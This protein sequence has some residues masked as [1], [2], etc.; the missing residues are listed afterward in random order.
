[1][2]TS[3]LG[4]LFFVLLL[5]PGF[6]YRLGTERR[7]QP[8][9]KH[10]GVSTFRETVELVTAS[11]LAVLAA[12]LVFAVYRTFVP[13]HSPD[14]G[15]LIDKQDAYLRQ[16]YAYLAWWALSLILLA[17]GLGYLGARLRLGRLF[18]FVPSLDDPVEQSAWWTAFE[19]SEAENLNKRIICHLTSGAI[20]EGTLWSY[21]PSPDDDDDREIALTA[22]IFMWSQRGS[23]VHHEAGTLIVSAKRIEFLY[24]KYVSDDEYDEATRAPTFTYAELPAS[25]AGY[26]QRMIRAVRKKPGRGRAGRP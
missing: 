23:L 20:V 21:N 2:P 3:A 26:A 10:G 25:P 18:R 19:W 4:A 7:Y 24:V 1:M 13:E 6:C 22:P 15:R 9:S 11:S 5:V 14:V 12:G 8:T 16:D 17:C